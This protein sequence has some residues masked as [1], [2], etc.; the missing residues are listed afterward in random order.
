[1]YT[2]KLY[3]TQ[4][5]SYQ[6]NVWDIRRNTEKKVL[7][8]ANKQCTDPHGHGNTISWDESKSVNESYHSHENP[9]QQNL[10]EN[11]SSS[12][13][14]NYGVDS[15]RGKD[16][17]PVVRSNSSDINDGTV[18]VI[19][20]WKGLMDMKDTILRQKHLQIERWLQTIGIYTILLSF[21]SM[22]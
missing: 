14:V 11:Y 17:A 12:G 4:K 19:E 15:L 18:G 2:A 8:L 21:S 7:N 6:E 20:K 13:N 10:H 3:I 22:F 9:S 16:S 1:M 5:R